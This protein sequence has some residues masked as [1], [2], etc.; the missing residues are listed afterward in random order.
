MQFSKAL[1][2]LNKVEKSDSLNATMLYLK[3]ETFLLKGMNE[4]FSYRDKLALLGN[5]EELSVLKM[6]HCLFIGSTSFDSLFEAFHRKYPYN[7]ELKYCEWLNRLNS[8]DFENC[9]KTASSFSNKILFGFAPYLAL[10]YH[11]W[12]RNPQLA[13]NYLDTLEWMVGR[14]HQSKYREILELIAVNPKKEPSQD[15]IELPFSWCGHGMGYY[16]IDENGD[17]IKIELDTGTG[18]GLM[19]IHDLEKGKTIHGKD[20]AVI[21]NGIQYNYMDSP[22]DLYYKSLNLSLPPYQNFL[23]GYF[24]GQFSKAD[25]CA[26]PFIFKDYALQI[27]PIAEKV[28]L[29]SEKN[30]NNYLL[31]NKKK[32]ETVAYQLRNGWIYI[33]CTVNGSEI[34]MMVETGSREINFNIFSAQVL[35]LETYEGTVKWRGKDYSLKKVDCNIE[36]GNIK[37]QLKGGLISDFV[38]GNWGYGLASAGDIGPDF[39]KNFVF[40]IDPFHKQIIFEVPDTKKDR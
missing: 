18:Y 10:Y 17:S 27:D 19:S 2:Q 6:K 8:G 36:I 39:L 38:L 26:S 9:K 28:F 1:I 21:R 20:I 15:L 29:R 5:N 14:F 30:L 13:L 7:D 22:E 25:G 31:Q 11:A 32:I 3:A 33:P 12:D 34:M 37:Y 35:G 24:D 4:Y 16:I 23:L 40:T